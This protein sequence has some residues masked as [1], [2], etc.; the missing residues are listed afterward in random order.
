MLSRFI[1]LLSLLSAFLAVHGEVKW[2]ATDYDF[3]IFKEEDG[4]VTGKV[5]F[6]N[7]GPEATFIS[8]VRPSCGCTGASYTQAM[9]NPGDTASVSFT[10]NP[11]GRPGPFDKTV[12]VYLGRENDLTVIRI[13]GTVIGSASTLNTYYPVECGPLRLDSSVLPVGDLKQGR[14]RHLFMNVYNQGDSPLR[15]VWKSSSNAL[16]AE[17]NPPEINPGETAT[18]T[19]LIKADGELP[20]GPFELPLQILPEGEGGDGATVTV[21]G[22]IVPDASSM[23]LEKIENAP[24]AFLLPEF[25]DLGEVK[26]GKDPEFEFYVLNEGKEKLDVD[27]VYPRSG[28]LVIKRT[29]SGIK[30]GGKGVVKGSVRLSEL[31]DGPFRLKVEVQTNDPFHPLRT[32]DVVGIKK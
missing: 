29:P 6:V 32:C 9:V 25:I 23:P 4:K 12:K 16:T 8:R 17:L 7:L 19:F 1:I 28:G 3:G 13:H 14:S 15:P 27:R 10:Y 22:I 20:G 21:N 31:P 5:S 18:F 2:L 24:Q 30:G 11:Q 26:A